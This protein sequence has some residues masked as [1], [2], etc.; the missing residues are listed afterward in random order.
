MTTKAIQALRNRLSSRDLAIVG[1]V[2][3]LRL[4]SAIQIQALLF[5]PAEHES[6]LAAARS[7]R[8]VLERLVRD[9]LLV[10]PDRRVGGVRAGSASYLY[11]L[12]EIGQRVLALGGPRRRFREPSMTFADHTL[13]VSQLVVDLILVARASAIEVDDVQPEPACWRRFA[14]PLGFVVLRPDLFVALGTKEYEFRWFIEVDR[15]TEHLPT[16]MAKCRIYDL[17]YRTGIEQR[18]H[19]V[20]PRVCWVVPDAERAE[21]LRERVAGDDRL[22]RGLFAVATANEAVDTLGG[23]S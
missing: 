17:Y 19:G 4:M 3:E 1:Q 13:A 6:D 11:T 5:S 16:L 7:A 2:A 18:A 14:G 12:G 8:R 10:R 21:A 23:G 20:F 22:P 9:R 15:G